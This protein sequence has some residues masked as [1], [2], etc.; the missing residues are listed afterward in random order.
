MYPTGRALI[1]DHCAL[2]V[3]EGYSHGAPLRKQDETAWRSFLAL[4][5][6][7]WSIFLTFSREKS[8][9]IGGFKGH[10]CF[11][12]WLGLGGMAQFLNVVFS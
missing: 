10:G 11:L 12:K 3:S 1:Q 5:A 7:F 9:Q 6:D 8:V 2:P 4:L